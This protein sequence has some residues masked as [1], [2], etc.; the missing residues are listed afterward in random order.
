MSKKKAAV[1][2]AEREAFLQGAKA[3]GVEEDV[4]EKLFTDMES[5]ANYAFN[6][7]HAAAYGILSYRTAYLKCHYPREYFSA[8]L[9]SVLGNQ[10]KIAEYIAECG[11]RGIR[12]LP[13]DINESRMY[14][15]V[16]GKNIRFGLLALK[17]VGKQFL[18]QILRERQY[19]NFVSFE[20]FIDRMPASELNKRMVESLIR[21]GT[22]D[23]LG[24]Y[25]SQMLSMHEIMIDRAV[26]KG[27]TRLDGQLDMF[28]MAGVERQQLKVD[29]PDIPEMSVREKLLMEKEAS[30]LYFSGQMLDEYS[31]HLEV[32]KPDS[33]ADF[34]SEDADPADKAKARVAGIITSVTPKTTRKGDRMMFFTL[35]D[36]M[37]E[38]ECIAFTRQCNEYGH[39][40]RLDAGVFVTGNLSVREDEPPKL[41]V[42]TVEPLVEDA[43]F[44]PE[45][46]KAQHGEQEKTAQAV[47]Q[48]STPNK[49]D[50]APKRLFLRV[51]D[52]EGELYGKAKNLTEL[53]DGSFPA[54][55]YNA[56]AKE[57]SKS[58]VGIALSDYVIAQL[59]DLLGSENVILK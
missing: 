16:S 32:L 4:A 9:T 44:T 5:F 26:E 59:R 18:E 52:M 45:M 25:R 46:A 55:F 31:R 47:P 28:S 14:F 39:L 37:A 20:D 34:V 48:V 11:S 12:V 10:T 36:R 19:G 49:T 54:F 35:E 24:V 58:P 22:F 2:L 51:P 29:Y 57:Y 40:L 7:S 13:P 42:S 23:G 3:R 30:G 27:K 53:F 1:L 50:A 43:R 21:A 8:L 15:S 41:L 17:N 56:A 33:I 38:M 6:K